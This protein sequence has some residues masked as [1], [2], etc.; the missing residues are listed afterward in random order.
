MDNYI[1][2]AVVTF[3]DLTAISSAEAALRQSEQ[4]LQR[5]LE[6]EALGVIFFDHAGTMLS[7]NEVFLRMTGYMD[8]SSRRSSG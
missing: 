6:T 4:R 1:S 3:T 5:V 2:G 7:A 8:A